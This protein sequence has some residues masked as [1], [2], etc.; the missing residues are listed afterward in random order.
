M[1]KTAL[2]IAFALTLGLGIVSCSTQEVG[3]GVANNNKND[4]TPSIGK[5]G[6]WFIGNVDT[7]V[8]AY[9][10][11]GQDG[12]SITISS[13]EEIEVDGRKYIKV[14][15]SDNTIIE[16]PFFENNDLD[17]LTPYIKD[18]EWYIMAFLLE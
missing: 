9:G 13:S 18:G 16:I 11:P 12:V 4:T 15:F 17:A 3:N 8:S 7:G 6:N 14:V 10:K 1:K 2:K 5:N